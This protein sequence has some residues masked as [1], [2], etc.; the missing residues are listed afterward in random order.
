[1]ATGQGLE[2][3]TVRRKR[4]SAAGIKN[5][6]VGK[7]Y[8]DHG[9]FLLVKPSGARSW[10]QRLTIGG[11]RRD[12]GLGAWPYLSLAEAREIAFDNRR[13][14]RRGGDP[15][16]AKRTP[17]VPT[18][19]EA[20]E[21][22]IGLYQPTWKSPTKTA[23]L[24]RKTLD[25]Y[26]D[27]VIGRKSVAE[28]DTAD[29][30]AILSPIW[31][32]KPETARKVRQRIGAVM[33]WSIA[34]RHRLDDPT[35]DAITKAL[36]R[37]PQARAHHRALPH[38]AVEEA[39]EAVRTSDALVSTRLAF[40]FLVLTAARSGEVRLAKWDEVDFDAATWTVPAERMK[41]GREHCVP[42]SDRALAVLRDAREVADGSW[43]IFPSARGKAM[44]DS[45]MSKL[46]RDL[47]IGAVPH[48]FRSSFRDWCGESAKPREVAEAALAHRLPDK[49]EAAYARSDLFDRRR[50]LMDA[51]AAYLGGDG[52]KVVELRG[53]RHG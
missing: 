15:L 12:L 50:A 25:T 49:T 22:V 21:I 2:L 36:P 52:G 26:V 53:R 30:L 46:L 40:E 27:P 38:A 19:A 24:W 23:G 42:L 3:G 32:A 34:E 31:T 9:L 45:T 33:K 18:F 6:P 47:G 11:K 7:H 14:A 35:G 51:W 48:G 43:L 37:A 28:I 17:S 4:L 13:A 1:M 44:S 29:V 5:A 39:V 10:V 20:A 16:A 8:D 41:A